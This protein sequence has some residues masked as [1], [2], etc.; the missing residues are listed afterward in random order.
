[1]PEYEFQLPYSRRWLI[2]ENISPTTNSVSAVGA[3]VYLNRID[4][5]VDMIVEGVV[6][7]NGS[8]ISGDCVVGLYGPVVTEDTAEG[9]PLV[10]DSGAVPVA[11]IST[12]QYVE[13]T[14]PTKVKAGVYYIA[15]QFENSSTLFIRNTGI[16]LKQ[17][18]L[19]LYDIGPGFGPFTDPCPATS[20]N[21]TH[22]ICALGVVPNA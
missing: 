3:R 10:A 13:F 19:Q 5:P 2:P 22:P 20:G 11:G 16:A 9:S 17:D 18:G 4:I 7:R 12:S 15:I 1:M 8:T 21:L 14:T 6:F